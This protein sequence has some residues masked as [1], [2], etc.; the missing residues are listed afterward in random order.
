M[1]LFLLLRLTA[2]VAVGNFDISFVFSFNTFC[3]SVA[4]NYQHNDMGRVTTKF[5]INRI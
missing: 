4:K 1:H 5:Q 2:T 3:V